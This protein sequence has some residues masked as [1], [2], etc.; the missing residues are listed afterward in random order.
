MVN[1]GNYMR[2]LEFFNKIVNVRNYTAGMGTE[3]LV[4]ELPP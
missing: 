2:I 3:K 1:I 4:G